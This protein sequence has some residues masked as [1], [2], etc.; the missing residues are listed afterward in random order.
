[1]ATSPSPLDASALRQ[2]FDHAPV[3]MGLVELHPDGVLHLIGNEATSRL[4][5]ADTTSLAGQFFPEDDDPTGVVELFSRHYEE[6]RDTKKPVRF[7]YEDAGPLGTRY[8]VATVQYVGQSEA[9]VARFTYVIDD[10]TSETLALREIEASQERLRAF[11]E[12]MPYPVAMVDREM[13]YLAV[14]Q[15]WLRDY[16]LTERDILG[17]SHYEVFPETPGA[18]KAVHQRCLSGSVES[19]DGEAFQRADGRIDWIR[20][21]VR[22][23]NTSEGDVGGLVIYTEVITDE[24]ELTEA[25]RKSEQRFEAIFHSMFQFIGLM[26][27]DGTMLEAN[28]TALAF[29]DLQPEDVVGKPFWECHWWTISEDAQ[30]E[31]RDQI[32]RAAQGT[33][34]RYNAEV[35]GAEGR[36]AII[37]FSIKPVLDEDGQVVLLIPEGR[38]VTEQ[39]HTRTALEVTERRLRT[40]LDN[41]PMVLFG[42]DT[43]GLVTHSDGSGLA[44]LGI[45]PSEIVGQNV[46]DLYADSETVVDG[47][48]RV[49]AGAPTQYTSE[50][51][52]LVYETYGVP[53][54]DEKGVVDGML[55]VGLDITSRAAAERNLQE[56]AERSMLLYDIASRDGLAFDDHIRYALAETTR[57]LGLDVGL[58][59]RVEGLPSDP[60][61]RYTVD[62]S[63]AR[64]GEPLPP[65]TQ[66]ALQDTYCRFV[67]DNDDTV[68]T[69]THM[70]ASEQC[71][72]TCYAKFGLEAFIGI[73]FCMDNQPYG[74]LSFSA[75]TPRPEGFSEADRDLVQM[76]AQ[77][78]GVLVEQ[79]EAERTLLGARDRAQAANRAK[80]AFLAAMSHEIRTPMNSVIGFA[81]LLGMTDLTQQQHGYVDRIMNSGEHL[82]GLIEDL[83]D[84]S[85][86]EAGEMQLAREPF[87]LEP[88]VR[89]VL[90]ALAPQAAGKQLDLAYDLADTVPS[91]LVGD[92]RRFQQILI[93]LVG[94]AIKFTEEG[95][96]E[97]EV[98][99]QSLG[100]SARLLIHVRDT[101]IGMDEDVQARIFKAFTQA[102]LSTT[103]RFG[104]TGLGLA[105]SGRL[106][107]LMQGTIEVASTPGAGSTFTLNLP[108]RPAQT[109]RRVVVGASQTPLAGRTVLLVDDD[110]ASR[111]IVAEHLDQW[112]MAVHAV[113]NADE[114]LRLLFEGRTFDLGVLDML[115]PETTG[116]DLARAI[117]T[118]P[119][120]GALPLVVVSSAS[121]RVHAPG[122]VD[123][124]LLKPLDWRVLYER[125]VQALERQRMRTNPPSF[126]SVTVTPIPDAPQR[127]LRVLVAEDQP[128]NQF[129]V[130]NML[131]MLGVEVV[132]ANDGIEA[133]EQVE[134]GLFDV[135]L[136]D[137]QMPRLDG[138]EATRR[139]RT[140]I[141]LDR[142]PRIIA[143]TAHA[144]AEERRRCMDAG[145][146]GFV[147]KPFSFEQ[148]AE[149]L[150]LGA[151]GGTPIG[152]A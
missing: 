107:T 117:R 152:H 119:T 147:T 2:L 29:A 40:V 88:L 38:D 9:G 34:V 30:Q 103:R 61:A 17:Q 8:L 41:I 125:L 46:F 122:L 68:A 76:L 126:Q 101:G 84:F 75:S 71:E 58:V 100:D 45:A 116:L 150:R 105:I 50:I 98:A 130:L 129:V 136:M 81:E 28:T 139:I 124:V 95:R 137:V 106:A 42:T 12:H 123:A 90:E 47:I 43:E 149:E 87:A 110:A 37:D 82:L 32:A 134:Q 6:A 99:T 96:V 11:V 148:L 121:E 70:G 66:F 133:V 138:V 33:F 78:I 118:T 74:T 36:T 108:L 15:R 128:D 91:R 51:G 79:R 52:P 10:Q 27:P 144:L 14:S 109:T 1:M 135:V 111:A 140:Q 4:S 146:D 73:T 65:G 57:M 97:V 7:S 19:S 16:R 20:W 64:E 5:D 131:Q 102:D 24:V 26:K 35:L 54:F 56:R 25:R 83:L 115:M 13:R 23:W 80:S 151:F 63:F 114:A 31:L 113:S 86:I 72:A 69:I 127:R 77:W 92:E 112:G 49:L 62:V 141:A 143:L 22:P 93:N 145:M 89:G 44:K 94:N 132:V 59:S 53:T 85:K 39:V 104:G 60:D 3:S 21:E 18:W 120:G 48:Q 142:Q 67:W 55:G